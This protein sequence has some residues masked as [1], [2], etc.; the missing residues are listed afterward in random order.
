MKSDIQHFN[1]QKFSVSSSCRSFLRSDPAL[2]RHALEFLACRHA[3][4]IGSTKDCHWASLGTGC[5]LCVAQK[6]PISTSNERWT[7]RQ[8][9]VSRS[10]TI[11]SPF[12]RTYLYILGC[13]VS[14]VMQVLHVLGQFGNQPFALTAMARAPLAPEP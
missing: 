10:M 5:E 2:R 1:N 4:S 3:C 6:L 12:A 11:A 7:G 13:A 9:E 14:N 8:S